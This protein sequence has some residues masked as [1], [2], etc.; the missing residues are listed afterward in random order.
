M[1]D[2]FAPAFRVELNGS[3]LES[4]ISAN[5]EEVSVVSK[6]NGMDTFSLTLVNPYPELRW[7]HSDDAE[8]FKEGTSVKISLGYVDH[9]LPMFD[10]EITKISP[11]FPES[12]TPTITI[13]GHS[14]MHWLTGD[15]KTRTFRDM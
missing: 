14:R 12:G 6:P 10:G 1:T 15:R 5:V 2:Y 3:R 8:L 7:T 9:L 13:E 11:T 4:D